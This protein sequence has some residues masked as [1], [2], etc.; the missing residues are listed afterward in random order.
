ME[1]H[2]Y[3]DQSDKEIKGFAMIL[4]FNYYKA[5]QRGNRHSVHKFWA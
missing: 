2:H 1:S 4:P 5:L 3:V